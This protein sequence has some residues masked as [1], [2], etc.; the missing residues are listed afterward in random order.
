VRLSTRGR[1]SARLRLPGPPGGPP[2]RPRLLDRSSKE[3][4]TPYPCVERSY[5]HCCARMELSKAT[6]ATAW[7]Q[8]PLLHQG[9]PSARTLGRAALRADAGRMSQSRAT[10]TSHHG[11]SG[12]RRVQRASCQTSVG[13]APIYHGIRRA[14]SR[15]PNA[16]PWA[17]WLGRFL[18]STPCMIPLAVRWTIDRKG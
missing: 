4:A 18:S 1:S 10:A 7:L 15:D 14:P 17:N 3:V 6:V 9:A 13:Q 5:G 11:E 12:V 16:I 8:L 2:P